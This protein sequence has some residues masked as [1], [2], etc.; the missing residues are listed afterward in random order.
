MTADTVGGVWSYALE[1]CAAL[2]EHRVEVALATMGAPLSLDQLQAAEAIDNL[3]VF[4]SAYALEWMPEPWADVDAAGAWLLA[5]AR[6]LE[7][8]IVQINGYAHAALPFPAPVVVVCHSCVCSWWRA[9]K[10]GEAPPAWDEY[11]RRVLAGLQAADE[12]VAPTAAILDQVLGC[13][14]TPARGRVIPNGRDPAG[15][16]AG[17]AEPLVLAAGRL[18]DEAKNLAALDSAAE[19]L[20][21]P[22]HV[23]G[24]IE[25][26]DGGRV[27]VR[28][29]NLL[30]RLAPGEL[31]T[32]MGRAAIYALPARY[33]PFGLSAL[34]AAMSGCALV[35][36]DIPSLREVWADAALYADPDD[37]EALRDA[38]AGLIQDPER[39]AQMAVRAGDRAARFTPAPMAAAY[40][41]LYDKVHDQRGS[42]REGAA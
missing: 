20:P 21:W 24:P 17:S 40:R 28:A 2:G 38:L 30:G 4:E 12:V 31:A 36:G 33:E 37:P 27:G 42:A 32:W 6:E 10:G 34:E 9:V 23:A 3:E 16:R 22:V 19:G 11:R 7:P 26:P 41:A 29:A 1:L 35:L 5:L 18:W 14:P 13:Y 8:D 39:R 25:R 15:F